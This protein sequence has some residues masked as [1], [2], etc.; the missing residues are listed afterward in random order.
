[1]AKTEPIGFRL[2]PSE[3]EALAQAAAA[4]EW[5]ISFTARKAV[6]DWLRREGRLPPL[7]KDSKTKPAGNK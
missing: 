3:L 1:M 4:G 2:E 5:S 6:V 7:S